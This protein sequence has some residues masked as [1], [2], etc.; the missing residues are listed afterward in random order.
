V[1]V[2]DGQE[3]IVVKLALQTPEPRVQDTPGC[4]FILVVEC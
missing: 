4:H 1:V 2:R 3:P